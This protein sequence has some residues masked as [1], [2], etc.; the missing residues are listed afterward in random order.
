MPFTRRSRTHT[1]HPPP[2]QLVLKMVG[3]AVSGA[4]VTSGGSRA[5]SS[6]IGEGKLA[7]A[8]VSAAGST[9]TSSAAFA[10]LSPALAPQLRK[11][12]DEGTRLLLSH[13]SA[14]QG[15]SLPRTA[16]VVVSVVFHHSFKLRRHL[17]Q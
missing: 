8:S 4:E 6:G 9:A 12:L 1:H 3:D 2:T 13:R 17:V 11:K 14:W 16:F 5:A 10:A 15:A 7:E